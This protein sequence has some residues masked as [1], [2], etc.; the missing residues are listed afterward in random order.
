M[1]RFIAHLQLIQT[2]WKEGRA[3][4]RTLAPLPYHSDVLGETIVVPDDFITDLASVP[5]LPI[6]WLVAGGRGSRSAVL[7]DF[8]Y[9]FGR[10]PLRNGEAATADRRLADTVFRESLAADDISGAGPLAQRLMWLA[11]RLFGG[12][13]WS[14]DRTHTLNPIWFADGLPTRPWEPDG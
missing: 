13:A 12:S 8:A 11:V 1:S 9:Q 4:W 3:V 14:A 10:W 6:A 2:D 7:H 5:R